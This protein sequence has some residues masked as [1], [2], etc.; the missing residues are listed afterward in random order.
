MFVGEMFVWSVYLYQKW[1]RKRRHQLELQKKIAPPS[2]VQQLDASVIVDDISYQT[3]HHQLPETVTNHLPPLR[4]I[5]SLLFWIP[6]LCDL[7]ATTVSICYC[8]HLYIYS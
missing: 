8:N 7:T 5:K 6:T 1:E 4:G 2:S 3:I